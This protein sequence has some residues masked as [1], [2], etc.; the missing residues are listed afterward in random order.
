MNTTQP[1]ADRS[2]EKP[3]VILTP[4]GGK[5]PPGGN[6]FFLITLC[7]TGLLILLLLAAAVVWYLP[8][9][10]QPPTGLVQPAATSPGGTEIPA[11]VP[12]PGAGEADRL[13]GEWLRLQAG[14]EAEHISVWGGDTYAAIVETAAEADR[15]MQQKRF[16]EA[17]VKYRQ[18]AGEL[19]QLLGARGDLLTQALDHG[20]RALE[21]L[22]GA[23]AGSAFARALAI[24][25]VNK[26]AQQGAERAQNLERV[27]ALYH[28]ALQ[29]EKA[30]EPDRAAALLREALDLDRE[31]ARAAAALADIEA[32]LSA[33][34]YREAMSRVLAALD[35]RDPDA[36]EKALG[37]ARRLR[38]DDRAVADASLRLAELKKTVQ[39]RD[40]R[41]KAE[42][43]AAAENWSA[44]LDM[45]SRALD[46]DPH[47]AFAAAG[48]A[49]AG[50]RLNLD[51]SIRAVFAT[52]SR[53]Q[54]DTP[55]REAQQ[56]LAGAESIASPGPVLSAQIAELSGLIDTA[57]M[58]IELCLR[59]NNMTEVEIYHVGRFQPFR[60]IRLALRP[61][62]YIVVGRCPGFRDVRQTLTVT[63][64]QAGTLPVFTVS[65]EEPI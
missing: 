35:R 41:R 47:A 19:E 9:H 64:E 32:R 50:L 46:V 12:D 11:A 2:A 62:S 39:L 4:P 53:L 10:Q 49:E 65:C 43:A 59:S 51:R 54:E 18:A 30:D 6:H 28:E 44:A 13:L 60:E 3:S 26:P 31:F 5:A 27:L 57:S 33:R 24:D 55:L 38:S 1:P 29:R 14:A 63:A 25:P 20:A 52:P 23:S 22:D 36:A 8:R 40:L 16:T 48:K 21:Q 17:Q 61:G 15:L 34:Q 42:E 56:L 7:V 58:K 45:Y 37:E